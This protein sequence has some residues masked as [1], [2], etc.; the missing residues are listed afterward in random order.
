LAPFGY[1]TDPLVIFAMTEVNVAQ[2]YGAMLIGGLLAFG[3]VV[4]LDKRICDLSNRSPRSLSGCVN[5][6]FIVYCR[7]YS[8]ERWRAK[9]LVRLFVFESALSKRI[10]QVIATWYVRVFFCK[11]DC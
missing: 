5:M 6:Q 4:S 10:T 8:C 9:S 3:Y 11:Q 2:D 7:L 1:P